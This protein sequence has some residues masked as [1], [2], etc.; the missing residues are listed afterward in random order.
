MCT[1]KD[2]LK[3]KTV[4]GYKVAVQT[5][6]GVILSLFTGTEYKPGEVPKIKTSTRLHNYCNCVFDTDDVK[7]ATD[8]KYGTWNEKSYGKT[9]ILKTKK[10]VESLMLKMRGWELLI[11][12]AKVVIIKMKLSGNIYSSVMPLGLDGDMSTFSGDIIDSVEVCK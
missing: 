9:S 4:T 12:D 11:E 6:E 2:K 10:E 1:I 3:R 7:R 8:M 5:R